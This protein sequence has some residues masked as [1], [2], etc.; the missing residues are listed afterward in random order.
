MAESDPVRVWN[1]SEVHN[2]TDSPLTPSAAEQ[3][4]DQTYKI[5]LTVLFS[6]VTVFGIALNSLIVY[7]VYRWTEMRTPCNLF[8]VNIAVGDLAVASVAA[9]LRIVEVFLGWPFGDFLCRF[10]APMQ[11]MF[12]TV[13]VISHTTIALERFRAIVKP[14]KCKLSLGAAKLIIVGIWPACYILSSLPLAVLMT[15]QDYQGV[16]HCVIV[17]PIEPYRPIYQIYL[18]VLFIAVP[19]MVQSVAYFKIMKTLHTRLMPVGS[20]TS[21]GTRFVSVPQNSNMNERYRKRRRLI[22]TLAIMVLVFQV[23]YIPRGV[24][25]LVYEFGPLNIENTSSFAYADLVTL[26]FFYLKHVINPII[27]FATSGDFRRWPFLRSGC[28]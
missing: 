22:K 11:E 25:M 26:V 12:V 13:S 9:P 24:M 5:T 4:R 14:L 16:H 15:A 23:C 8:I 18:V 6:A 7:I 27:L 28:L 21:R 2:S 3:T 17:W 20:P 10:L 19:L 1:V